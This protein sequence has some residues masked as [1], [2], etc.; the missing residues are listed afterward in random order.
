MHILISVVWL[1]NGFYCKLLTQIPRHQLIVSRILGDEYAYE[2]TKLIGIA[3]IIM[4]IWILSCFRSRLNA[5]LQMIIIAAMN[6]IEFFMAK[7][8]LLFGAWN[9][10][11]AGVLILI[12]YLNEF[13]LNTK[14]IAAKS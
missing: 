6:T 11:W 2:L 8:L 10:A 3:E 13:H 5:I 9:A 7:D 14:D 4:A 1:I 12:I